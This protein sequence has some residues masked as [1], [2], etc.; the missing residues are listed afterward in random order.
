MASWVKVI[1]TEPDERSSDHRMD[2]HDGEKELTP[3]NHPLTST[4]VLWQACNPTHTW[5][6]NVHIINK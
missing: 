2:L 6:C 4:C 3:V 5:M 1:V